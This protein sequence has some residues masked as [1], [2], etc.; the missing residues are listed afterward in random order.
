MDELRNPAADVVAAHPCPGVAWGLVRDGVL[1]EHGGEGVIDVAGPESEPG[2]GPETPTCDTVYRIAS[3][4]KSFTC[5][6][7]LS[8]RDEGVLDLDRPVA[9]TLPSLGAL[10]GPAGSPRITLRHLMSMS[11][12][13]ATDDPW[14]DRHLDIDT[15]ELDAV[16]ASGVGFAVRT[17]DAFEYSNLGFG[18]IGRVVAEITGTRVREHVDERLLGPLGMNSTTWVE[19]VGRRWARPHRVRD[20]VLVDDG[21]EPLGDGEIAPMGGL[22]T[23]V[24]DLARWVAW[25]GA[26]NLAEPPSHDADRWLAASSRREMQRIQNYSGWSTVAGRRAPA[27]YG[28]GLRQFDDPSIGMIVGHSGGLP[29]YGSNMRWVASRGV[30]VIAL[31]NVTY[32]PMAELTMRMI[33]GLHDADL[34][35]SLAPVEA[36][37]VV[38]RATRLAALLS[39]WDDPTAADLFADNVA[40]DD[41]LDRRAAAAASL[42]AA[43][44][45][46]EVVRVVP[47]TAMAGTLVVR[48]S[49]SGTELRITL[50]L[51][52]TM[53]VQTYELPGPVA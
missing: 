11:A 10:N 38:E 24:S 35:P 2:S 41:P 37:L 25:L 30:G 39:D 3:M 40:P 46:L 16:L 15:A 1:V 43:H 33:V 26:A 53:L 51:A 34:I 44:G 52:P 14:A 22:W 12:G 7:V 20:G 6:A 18:A 17:G 4:T 19:P 45:R 5:A 42:V 13:M 21:M 28:F 8:L 47:S 32:A 29:G 49:T 48:G 27:G 50:S 36:P 23:T 31:S 9:D